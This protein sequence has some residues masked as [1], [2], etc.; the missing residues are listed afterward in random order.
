MCVP[1]AALTH[2]RLSVLFASVF[3]RLLPAK[4]ALT[5]YK[6]WNLPLQ[7]THIK[8]AVFSADVVLLTAERCVLF[9]RT[10]LPEVGVQSSCIIL[11]S[12]VS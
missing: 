6:L 12:L 10:L 9:T 4:A 8:G 3:A 1:T 11:C 2:Q 5:H 7:P